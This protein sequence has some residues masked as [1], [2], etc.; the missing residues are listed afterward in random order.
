MRIQ[1]IVINKEK[2]KKRKPFLKA[3]NPEILKKMYKDLW[4]WKKKI[5]NLDKLV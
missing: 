2:P 5:M 3:S 1:Q 4:E